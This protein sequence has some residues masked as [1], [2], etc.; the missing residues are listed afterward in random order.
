VVGPP[1]AIALFV[2]RGVDVN[3]AAKNGQTPLLIA[4]T[5]GNATVAAALLDRGAD[6]NKRDAS[7][8]GRWKRRLGPA[9]RGW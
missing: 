7:A 5:A 1:E 6:P 2:S 3:A 4:C 9:S 8:D